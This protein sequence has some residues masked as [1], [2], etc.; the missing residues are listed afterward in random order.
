MNTEYQTQQSSR[1][2]DTNRQTTSRANVM[3]HLASLSLP[4]GTAREWGL[5]AS[6]HTSSLGAV[7]VMSAIGS[8]AYNLAEAAEKE[9]RETKRIQE[10]R[11]AEQ[12]AQE[13]WARTNGI[14]RPEYAVKQERGRQGE[15]KAEQQVA[16]NQARQ[17]RLEEA[18]R[19]GASPSERRYLAENDT[20]GVRDPNEKSS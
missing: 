3:E 19:P 6:Q 12:K 4:F 8:A 5:R 13:E 10:K 9:S 17:R 7:G 20:F 1:H 14:T 11:E 2:V 16:Q 18:R 15:M